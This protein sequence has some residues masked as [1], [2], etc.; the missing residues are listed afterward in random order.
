[1]YLPL[2]CSIFGGYIPSNPIKPPCFPMVFLWFA[3]LDSRR[4]WYWD[5]PQRLRQP[6]LAHH[7]VVEEVAPQLVVDEGP[8]EVGENHGENGVSM[9]KPSI[10]SQVF[11]GIF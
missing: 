6:H 7:P 5:L 9:G 10:I 8:G 2:P 3:M 1:M 11:S 4:V